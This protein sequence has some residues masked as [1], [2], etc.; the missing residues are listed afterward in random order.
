MK[1]GERSPPNPGALDDDPVERVAS[2]KGGERSPPNGVEH[3]GVA[4]GHPGF[5]EGRGTFPA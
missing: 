2:M 5:N 3:V 1:G 4:A